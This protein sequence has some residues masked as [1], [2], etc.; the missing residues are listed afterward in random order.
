MSNTTTSSTEKLLSAC[1]GALVTSLMVT[2][3]DVVKMRMQTQNVYNAM[4]CMAF[5]NCIKHGLQSTRI[6][7]G[8]P[9]LYECAIPLSSFTTKA[10]TPIFKSTLDGLYKIMKYEGPTALWK[11]LSPAL[12]MSVPANVIYFV[13][14]DY[15][16]DIIQPIISTQATD[17]SPLIAGAV[18]RTLAVTI[19]SPI[20]LFRTRLQ[21]ATAVHDFK[22]VMEGVKKMVLQDGMQAL[23]R[24]LP[25]TLWRDVPFSAIYWMGYEQMKY[26]LESHYDG[27]GELQLSFLSGALSGMFAATITTPFDVAKTRRQVDAGRE[28]PLLKDT[29][30]PAILRQIYRQD[31]IRGLFSGLTPRVA[32]IG[33]SCAIMISSYEMGKTF[34]SSRK[35]STF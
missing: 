22:H 10:T 32:K 35:A 3:M 8:Q 13:G 6:T 26:A 15:L 33:P 20:E 19:I 9:L 29:R 11:G 14:Y 24:G 18:A 5:N 1:G 25:P 21:A 17:Y 23:W 4:C 28:I 34:F 30:V 12:V 16:K 31:G 2:P 27:L 7:R